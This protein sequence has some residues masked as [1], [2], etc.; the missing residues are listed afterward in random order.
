MVVTHPFFPFEVGRFC[1]AKMVEEWTVRFGPTV[2][3]MW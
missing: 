3:I 2:L 1:N